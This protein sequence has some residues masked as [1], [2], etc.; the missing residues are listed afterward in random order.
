MVEKD[1]VE[2]E[3]EE[4]GTRWKVRRREPQQQMMFAAPSM[5]MPSLAAPGVGNPYAASAPVAAV[6][7]EAKGE[8]F[9]SP[10]LGTFIAALP[11]GGSLRQARR[12]GH[13]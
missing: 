2:V 4:Q 11:R 6:A 5:A 8:V 12:S 9:K 10:M 7:A 1:I 13:G 3:V